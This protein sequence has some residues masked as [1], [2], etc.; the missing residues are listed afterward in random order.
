MWLATSGLDLKGSMGEILNLR[1]N[2]GGKPTLKSH[3]EDALN[4]SRYRAKAR[5]CVL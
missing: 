3:V 1:D 4:D 5:D 2:N